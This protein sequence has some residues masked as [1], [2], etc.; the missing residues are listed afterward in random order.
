M[1]QL[2]TNCIVMEY[3]L[4]AGRKMSRDGT[5]MLRHALRV[6]LEASFVFSDL[7]SLNILVDGPSIPD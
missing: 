7:R 1:P 3:I 6:L 5:K 2:R 4:D